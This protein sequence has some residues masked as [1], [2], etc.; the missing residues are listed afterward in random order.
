MQAL[1]DEIDSYRQNI[2]QLQHLADDVITAQSQV[3]NQNKEQ[4]D[5]LTN[6]IKERLTTINSNYTSLQ[7]NAHQLLVIIS[8][9]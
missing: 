8:I 2:S 9:A 7:Q 6:Q 4:L 3:A 1:V 5:R